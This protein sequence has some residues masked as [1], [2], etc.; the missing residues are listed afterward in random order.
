MSVAGRRNVRAVS[1]SVLPAALTT[2]VRCS[3]VATADARRYA[4]KYPRLKSRLPSVWLGHPARHGRR[5]LDTGLCPARP[6]MWEWVGQVRFPESTTSRR[7]IRGQTCSAALSVSITNRAH[8]RS[9]HLTATRASLSLFRKCDGARRRRSL[10]WRRNL[11]LA[12]R[13]PQIGSTGGEAGCGER[14]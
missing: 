13:Q 4:A 2:S 14:A 9:K 1:R 5:L 7:E 6:N 3:A 11:P 10:R 8:H 12:L